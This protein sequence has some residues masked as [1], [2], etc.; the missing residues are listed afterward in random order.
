MALVRKSN[1]R[2]NI[3]MIGLLAAAIVGGGIW[4]YINNQPI[5]TDD[6]SSAGGSGFRDISKIRQFNSTDFES[7]SIFNRPDYQSLQ[8]HG[9]PPDEPVET[10][11]VNPFVPSQ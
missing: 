10:G 11:V 3:M 7:S 4:L 9:T 1:T 5:K 6:G 8:S 2:R